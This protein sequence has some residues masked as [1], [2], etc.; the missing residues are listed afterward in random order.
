MHIYWHGSVW[1][2]LFRTAKGSVAVRNFGSN[3]LI[4][5]TLRLCWKSHGIGRVFSIFVVPQLLLMIEVAK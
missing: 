2:L 1:S 5:N 3:N 4:G